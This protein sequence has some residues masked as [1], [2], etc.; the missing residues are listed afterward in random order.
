MYKYLPFITTLSHAHTPVSAATLQSKAVPASYENLAALGEAFHNAWT[1][2]VDKTTNWLI[3]DLK[4]SQSDPSYDNGYY[5][6]YAIKTKVPEVYEIFHELLGEGN[7]WPVPEFEEDG[8]IVKHNPASALSMAQIVELDELPDPFKAN[9]S[10]DWIKIHNH[11]D[12]KEIAL[13]EG[14]DPLEIKLYSDAGRTLKKLFYNMQQTGYYCDFTLESGQFSFEKMGDN[15]NAKLVEDQRKKTKSHWN[16]ILKEQV[17]PIRH[18]LQMWT[19][20]NIAESSVH[21]MIDH[22]RD[23][24]TVVSNTLAELP[25]DKIIDNL[26]WDDYQERYERYED[27]VKQWVKDFEAWVQIC[28]P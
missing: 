5:V 8:F 13:F 3:D 1:D 19:R 15:E 25:M 20:F 12:N 21:K 18:S 22:F 4:V 9:E 16:Y 14:V 17:A 10:Q 26:G 7:Y 6:E 28:Y 27:I 24:W 23:D 2:C 11:P